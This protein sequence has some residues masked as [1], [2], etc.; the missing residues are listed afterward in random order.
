M[1]EF[2]EDLFETKN[3]EDQ[4][5][6]TDID[7]TLIEDISDMNVNLS[8]VF[9]KDFCPGYI[10]LG[11]RPEN[12]RIVIA[13]CDAFGEELSGNFLLNFVSCRMF[14]NIGTNEVYMDATMFSQ[15]TVCFKFSE[16]ILDQIRQCKEP[17]VHFKLILYPQ[18]CG[19]QL[20]VSSFFHSHN[21]LKLD[22]YKVQELNKEVKFSN[23]SRIKSGSSAYLDNEIKSFGNVD[24]SGLNLFHLAVLYNHERLVKLLL[25]HEFQRVLPELPFGKTEDSSENTPL[26]LAAQIGSLV[27]CK[28]LIEQGAQVR[29]QNK[30]GLLPVDLARRNKHFSVVRFLANVGIRENII[31]VEERSITSD[32]GSK[33]STTSPMRKLE[34]TGLE[35][36]LR[37]LSLKDRMAVHLA[38]ATPS[39]GGEESTSIEAALK[40]MNAQ[41][42][43]EMGVEVSKIQKNFRKWLLRK[44]IQAFA[45]NSNK[46]LEQ[47]I[48]SIIIIQRLVRQH[49]SKK[50]N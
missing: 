32:S 31:P 41:E 8:T 14:L 33:K 47:Q 48:K 6:E 24:S 38:N 5:M 29:E 11:S 45:V 9:V 23:S 34:E 15:G 49:Q 36:A 16:E 25:S 22:V 27:L 37:S 42:K 17:K 3:E 39:R 21:S 20:R 2:L 35:E 30:I 1:E 12:C 26:H 43:K 50:K 7:L 28:L 19:N 13:F 18:N 46:P 44:K 4:Y 10:V 40:L